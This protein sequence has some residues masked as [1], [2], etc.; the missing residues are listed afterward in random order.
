MV[1][2]RSNPFGFLAKNLKGVAKKEDG[3]LDLSLKFVI[4]L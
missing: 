2:I 4:Q 1:F 3:L